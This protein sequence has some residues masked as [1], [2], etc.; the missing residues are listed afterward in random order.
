MSSLSLAV[1]NSLTRFPEETSPGVW[2]AT[3][4]FTADFLG[5]DGHFPGDPMLPG[6]AQIMAAAF[7]ASGGRDMRIKQV[8]RTKFMSMV[9]PDDT[10]HVRA[11][12]K[13]VVDGLAVT[14]D[15]SVASGPCAHIKLVLAP[16]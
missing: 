12:V 2:E 15:C 11:A 5:F 16:L 14:A 4:V 3:C 8:G 1:R 7:T 13:P 6:V 9:R 10:L